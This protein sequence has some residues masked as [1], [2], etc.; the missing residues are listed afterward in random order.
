MLAVGENA[1]DE[2]I[3]NAEVRFVPFQSSPERM[4]QYYRA[5]DIYLHAAK[6]DTFPTTILEA[7]ACGTPVIAT[8][9]GGIPEQVQDGVT[10]YLTP[11][12]DPTAMAAR[13]AELLDDPVGLQAMG[14]QAATVARHKFGLERMADDYLDWYQEVFESLDAAAPK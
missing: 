7:M 11:P 12:R 3:R 13:I 8:A 6:S 5:A 1:P 2:T 10:G 9:V 14:A 4:A